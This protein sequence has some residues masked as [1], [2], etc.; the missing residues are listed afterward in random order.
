[1]KHLASFFFLGLFSVN[2]FGVNAELFILD[3]E[4][5]TSEFFTLNQLE[6]ILLEKE[7]ISESELTILNEQ[8]NLNNS[9]SSGDTSRHKDPLYG[10]PAFFWGFVPGLCGGFF[11]PCI[12]GIPL[13]IGSSGVGIVANLTDEDSSGIKFRDM[14]ETQKAFLGCAAGSAVG[15][16]ISIG[17]L[18]YYLGSFY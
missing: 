1:M 4:K 9:F 11:A 6:N 13:I 15:L 7:N 3:E 8:Y 18:F 16:G 2:L 10:I 5:I 14:V 12:Y 17:L